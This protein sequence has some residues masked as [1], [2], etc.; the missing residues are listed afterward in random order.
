MKRAPLAMPLS[1]LLALGALQSA[2]PGWAKNKNSGIFSSPCLDSDNNL[3]NGATIAITPATLW[4][5][6]HQM[7]KV[8]ISM[9]LNAD[10][11]S[12]VPVSFSITSITDDQVAD[13]DAGGHGCGQKTSKQ[14]AD[15]SP[16]GLNEQNPFTVSGQLQMSTDAIVTPPGAVEL[17]RERCGKDGSRVYELEVTCGDTSNPR[18][19]V[20]D[21][22]PEVLE[23]AVPHDRRHLQSA[24]AAAGDQG[25]GWWSLVQRYRR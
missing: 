5:P 8:S 3:S 16:L 24:Q 11:N 1:A 25:S 17:R 10:A 6:Q 22:G 12:S 14:G 2:A 15:W 9:M 18:A 19:A 4:P 21:G 20:R 7:A 13:D 23:V